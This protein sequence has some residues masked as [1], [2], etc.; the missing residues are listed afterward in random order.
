MPAK[1]YVRLEG[2]KGMDSLAGEIVGYTD[3]GSLCDTP[4]K[5]QCRLDLSSGETVSRDIDDI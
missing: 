4:V 2:N 3:D 5:D 1:G